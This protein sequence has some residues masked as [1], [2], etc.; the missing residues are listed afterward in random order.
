MKFQRHIDRITQG[1]MLFVFALLG[2]ASLSGCGQ[3]V[4]TPSAPNASQATE[5]ALDSFT[6]FALSEN[7]VKVLGCLVIAAALM[8]VKK[9]TSLP[10][11]ALAAFVVMIP[12]VYVSVK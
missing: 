5:S 4:N 12:I 9:I 3:S 1:G 10:W 2:L 7:G 8:W 6:R 11:W